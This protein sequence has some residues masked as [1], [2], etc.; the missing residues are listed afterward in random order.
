M[1]FHNKLNIRNL[2]NENRSGGECLLERVENITIKEIKLL[3][4][5]LLDKAYQ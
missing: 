5:I 1:S 4:N 3:R 2:V